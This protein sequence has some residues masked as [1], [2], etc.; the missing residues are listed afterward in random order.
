[1]RLQWKIAARLHSAAGKRAK[2]HAGTPCTQLGWEQSGV[3]TK[4]T[5]TQ[6]TPCCPRPT[7]PDTHPHT[8]D[9]CAH[10]H[11]APP[12]TRP[13]A[14]AT[15]PRCH[16]SPSCHA[17]AGISMTPARAARPAGNTH[18]HTLVHSCRRRCLHQALARAASVLGS[19]HTR[20]ATRSRRKRLLHP[21]NALLEALR[22]Q[23]VRTPDGATAA[24]HVH[25]GDVRGV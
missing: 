1:V 9:R 16:L 12:A 15:R 24:A 23:L 11:P 10:H 17:L 25:T 14:R 13:S 5:P 6:S 2:L 3:G 19:R 18:V 20:A 4:A 7:G 21:A 22:R 8:H